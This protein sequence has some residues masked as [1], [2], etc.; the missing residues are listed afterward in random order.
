MTTVTET[1][2]STR[3]VM[4]GIAEHLLA[5]HQRRVTGSIRLQVREGA[6]STADLPTGPGHADNTITRLELRSGYLVR[7]PEGLVVPVRGTFAALA[8]ELGVEFGMPD[9]PYRPASG[10]ASDSVAGL[11]PAAT[12]LIEDAW[13]IG[14]RALRRLSAEQPVVWPEHLDVAITLDEVNYGVSPG[15]GYTEQPYAYV[16][17]HTPRTGGFWNAPFGAARTVTEL[18]ASG[19]S[20]DGA[21][22]VLAFFSEGQALTAAP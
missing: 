13:R 20:G 8:S 1:L 2:T 5:A 22:A 4:H 19:G 3:H 15:D 14:H 17:P 21:D 6:L 18:A 12:A 10:C 7:H 16:G 9:P 11:D